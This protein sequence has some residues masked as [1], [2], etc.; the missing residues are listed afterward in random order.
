MYRSDTSSSNSTVSSMWSS[1]PNC[2]KCEGRAY[3]E[4]TC[5]NCDGSGIFIRGT[6]YCRP[7]YRSGRDAN[8]S[9]CQGRG[10]YTERQRC[11]RCDGRGRLPPQICCKGYSASSIG[12]QWD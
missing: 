3:L 12:S 6:V 1:D 9:T 11:G 2:G 4:V 8:C 5:E 7:C 10:Q